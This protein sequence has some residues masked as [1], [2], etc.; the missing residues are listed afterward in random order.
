MHLRVFTHAILPSLS[1][2]C[3]RWMPDFSRLRHYSLWEAFSPPLP[4]SFTTL[5]R[6]L[7]GQIALWAYLC[8]WT[9]DRQE[10]N[11]LSVCVFVPSFSFPKTMWPSA[12]ARATTA[13]A[14]QISLLSELKHYFQI[15]CGKENL[16]GSFQVWEHPFLLY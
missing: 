16:T 9:A 1:P 5:V 8:F 13:S 14:K 4:Y 7:G 2:Y 12:S 3:A 6:N 10:W 11:Y 15:P